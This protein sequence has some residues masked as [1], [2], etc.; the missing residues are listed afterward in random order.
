MST[1][2]GV[3][4]TWMKIRTPRPASAVTVRVGSYETGGREVEEVVVVEV[5]AFGEWKVWLIWSV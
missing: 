3:A 5:G 4:A 1:A 2:A